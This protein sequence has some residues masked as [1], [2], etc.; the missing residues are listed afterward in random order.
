MADCFRLQKKNER[1]NKPKSPVLPIKILRD[2]GAYQSL[3]LE[4][5]LPLSKEIFVGASVLL[6]GVELGCIDGP[7][8][9]IDLK[10][11]LITSW[12]GCSS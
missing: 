6:Q 9:R 1:E 8:H 5:V 10:S 3:L 12:C 7:L 11:D 4:G 2:T